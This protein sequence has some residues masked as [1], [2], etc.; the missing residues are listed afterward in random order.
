MEKAPALAGSL[1]PRHKVAHRVFEDGTSACQTCIDAE[2]RG[3]QTI[4]VDFLNDA[5]NAL[6]AQQ[7]WVPV[8][9][10]AKMLSPIISE[11]PSY[12]IAWV[13]VALGLRRHLSYFDII[14]EVHLTGPDYFMRELSQFS[15]M[16][17]PQHLKTS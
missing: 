14:D 1:C 11:T 12:S 6:S 3:L 15:G 10:Q 2:A 4:L 5:I 16:H 9:E 7:Q 13:I 8:F 17:F